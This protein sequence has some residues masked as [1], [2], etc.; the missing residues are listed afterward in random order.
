[1]TASEGVGQLTL[2]MK[3]NITGSVDRHLLRLDL[4]HTL[5]I[6][7]H[8]CTDVGIADGI[9]LQDYQSEAYHKAT[10][11]PRDKVI[12]LTSPAGMYV[13]WQPG[14]HCPLTQQSWW[15]C[16]SPPT[17]AHRH[18]LQ[19]HRPWPLCRCC[20]GRPRLQKTEP[21]HRP[22]KRNFEN[23]GLSAKQRNNMLFCKMS[24]SA[25]QEVRIGP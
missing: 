2:T 6:T 15:A 19:S 21:L 18:W 22:Q 13:M 9:K 7:S 24:C 16:A 17:A 23:A 25:D 5:H 10:A 3:S 8:S 14:C 11:I 1:M 12:G 20:L 4:S